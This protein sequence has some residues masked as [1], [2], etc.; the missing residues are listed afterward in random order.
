MSQEQEKSIIERDIESLTIHGL[1]RVAS[2]NNKYTRIV[3]LM[4]CIC[5]AIAFGIVGLLS[6]IKYHQYQSITHTTVKHS[7]KLALPAIT[8]CHKYVSIPRSF[9]YDDLPV[10]QSLPKNCSFNDR[11]HFASTMNWRIFTFL[12]R[13]FFGTFNSRTSA[14]GTEYPQYF[15]FPK[16][17]EITPYTKPCVTLNRNLTLVQQ[18]EG[19]EYGLHMI[20]YNEDYRAPHI[21]STDEPLIDERNG[22]YALIHDPKQVVPMGDGNVLLPGYHTHI[23][24]TKNIIKRLPHPYPSNCT[25]DRSDRDSI[26]PGKNTQKLCINSCAYKQMYEMCPG[27][28]PEM[29]VFMKASKYPVQADFTNDSFWQCIWRSLPLINYQHCDCREH[30]YDETYIKVINRSPWP[31]HWEIP[32]LLKLIESVEGKTN[33]T[34]SANDIRER[35]MKLSIYYN[36]FKENVSEEKPLYDLLTII[37]DLG[38]QMGLFMGAS[39]LSLAEII[40]LLGQWLKRY[41]CRCDKSIGMSPQPI[42]Q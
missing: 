31:P 19:E 36:E 34:L 14:M 3:W 25:N 35:L 28:L 23:S 21:V 2:A 4:L 40:A 24:V 33:N 18:A 29:R 10:V 9:N 17:F 22:I 27:V 16:G 1:S 38:G 6:L 41:L 12:C 8:F 42:S 30:C 37:S 32:S 20:M 15:Q 26:Y 11:K 5:A 7:N 13:M 39:L